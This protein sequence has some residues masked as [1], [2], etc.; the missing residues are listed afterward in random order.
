MPEK[1]TVERR[2]FLKMAA[3][4]AGLTIVPAAAVRGTTANSKVEIGVIGCGGRG[5][6]IG[7]LFNRSEKAK[8]VAVHDYS[9]SRGVK[10]A[11]KWYTR[12]KP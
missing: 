12:S 7:H 4:S 5:T 10:T 8:V 2:D 11:R 9:S 6:W 1:Q 3:V